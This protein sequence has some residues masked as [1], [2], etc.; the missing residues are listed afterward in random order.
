MNK[1]PKIVLIVAAIILF[2]WLPVIP[3]NVVPEITLRVI[4]VDKKPMSS[5]SVT[6]YWIHY[7]FES[8][9]SKYHSDET[10]SDANGYV[11]FSEKNL[12]ISVFKFLFGKFGEFFIKVIPTHASS[13]IYS[14]FVPRGYLTEG[15][16]CFSKCRDDQLKEI[17]IK[18]KVE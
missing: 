2:I 16:S 13:G 9:S 1:R 12:T 10:L 18:R 3:I 7:S 15:Y 14:D 4:D 17:V 8:S 5:I 11:T 6:Q